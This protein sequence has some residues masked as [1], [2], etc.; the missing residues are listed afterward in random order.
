MTRFLEWLL[1]FFARRNLEKRRCK[2]ENCGDKH[3]L[4]V[5]DAD[6]HR[7]CR[8][9]AHDTTNRTLWI[10]PVSLKRKIVPMCYLCQ[11]SRNPAQERARSERTRKDWSEVTTPVNGA[12]LDTDMMND[13]YVG[14]VREAIRAFAASEDEFATVASAISPSALQNSISVLG[15]DD[16]MYAEQRN[17]TTVLRRIPDPKP[18]QK[19]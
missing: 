6:A 7:K 12:A 11:H 19:R 16:K 15:L 13:Q 10:D 14:V 8:T 9:C 3:I 18:G 4:C 2:L 17:D 1:D 5:A